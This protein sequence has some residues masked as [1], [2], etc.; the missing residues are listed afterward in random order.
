MFDI[1]GRY[2]SAAAMP[3]SAEPVAQRGEGGGRGV[4]VALVGA[5]DLDV[6]RRPEGVGHPRDDVELVPVLLVRGAAGGPALD[7]LVLG[8]AL[9]ELVEDAAQVG[10]GVPGRAQ[11][12]VL[13]QVEAD[14]GEPVLGRGPDAVAE[15]RAPDRVVAEDELGGDHS[16]RW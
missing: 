4:E 6:V 3:R 10:V 15:A 7:D 12:L 16:V 9:P 13:A 2:S 1:S 11:R 8:H 5:D 14:A